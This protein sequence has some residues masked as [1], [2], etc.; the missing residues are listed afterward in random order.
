MTLTTTTRNGVCIRLTDE[1]W[2]YIVEEGTGGELFAAK[3]MDDGKLL[4]IVYR[5]T[6]Q[7]AGFII[8]AFLTRRSRYLERRRR[9]WP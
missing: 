4:V 2:L 3:R 5:E 9:V 6:S 1:R 8:T 7:T